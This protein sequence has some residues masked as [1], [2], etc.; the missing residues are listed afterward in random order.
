MPP[1]IR[2]EARVNS[3]DVNEVITIAEINSIGKYANYLFTIF[4]VT[5]SLK[6]KS[7]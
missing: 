7:L 3:L 5:N 1:K 4:F 2:V 6:K